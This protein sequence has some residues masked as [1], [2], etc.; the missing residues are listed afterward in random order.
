MDVNAIVIV[1]GLVVIVG[2]AV[3]VGVLVSQRR[4]PVTPP[5]PNLT[6]DTAVI[7]GAARDVVRDSVDAQV[8]TATEAVM[9]S[10]NA[11]IDRT[12][13]ALDSSAV[14]VTTASRAWVPS[15]ARTA[16]SAATPSRID[17]ASSRPESE[18]TPAPPAP[19][20]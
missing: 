5:A 14:A 2:L 3:A 13:Q 8:R 15:A 7:T 12:Y 4:E 1:A 6:I 17:A 20:R 19:P 10:L 9:Q 18:L 16:T 11:Q